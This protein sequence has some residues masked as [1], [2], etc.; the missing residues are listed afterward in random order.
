VTD[1]IEGSVLL[2]DDEATIV[3]ALSPALRHAGYA[4][5]VAETGEEALRMLAQKQY[6]VL[7]LDLGLPGIDGQEVIARIR[8]WSDMPI[9]VLSARDL[10]DDK[11]MALDR[12]ADDYVSKP[13]AI[14]E[15]LARVR[16]SI[17]GR[18]RRF[19][20][21]AVFRAAGLTINFANRQVTLEGTVVRLTPR[22]YEFVKALASH[23]GKVL[24]H[25]QLIAAVW[26]ANSNADAQFVRVLAGQVR[27]KIEAD[28]ARPQLIRTEPGIGYRLIAEG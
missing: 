7:L 1:E 2:V 6:D 17:R 11:I 21:N 24:T 4:V 26:G 10:E 12:G 5:E 22:E 19:A 14:G 9:V 25:K 16:A 28:P 13:F 15:L 20:S 3:R 27:H 18:S 23:A 8:E